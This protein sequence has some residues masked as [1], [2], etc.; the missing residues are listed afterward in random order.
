MAAS[1][2]KVT[3]FDVVRAKVVEVVNRKEDRVVSLDAIAAD[4]AGMIRTFS[5]SGRMLIH[6]GTTDNGGY[7]SVSNKT[8]EST[9]DIAADD[10]GNGEI[11]AYNRKGKGRVWRSR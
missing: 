5:S 7:L 6:M 9:A 2:W 8:D 4:H 10:Y 11:D 1:S 3:E